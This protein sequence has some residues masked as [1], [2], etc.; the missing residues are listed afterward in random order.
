MGGKG[1]PM[2]EDKNEKLWFSN[3]NE[4]GAAI[5]RSRYQ[6]PR[7]VRTEDLPAFKFYGRWTA[8]PIEIQRWCVKQDRKHRRKKMK[9]K[10]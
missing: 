4:I 1:K 5:G 6:I 3:A 9:G 10:P 8:L 7:L 2:P